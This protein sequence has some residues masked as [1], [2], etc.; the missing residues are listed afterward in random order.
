MESLAATVQLVE[1]AFSNGLKYTWWFITKISKFFKAEIHK[2]FKRKMK[3]T[4]ELGYGNYIVNEVQSTSFLK[5]ETT[6]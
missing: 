6:S 4:I 2:I 1:V 3:D 5:T